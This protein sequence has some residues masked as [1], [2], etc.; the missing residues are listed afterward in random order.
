MVLDALL[1]AAVVGVLPGVL[2]GRLF[3]SRRTLLAIGGAAAASS[4]TAFAAP[5]TVPLP[6]TGRLGAASKLSVPLRDLGV[7][8]QTGQLH[9]PNWLLGSWRLHN[10]IT[11]FTMPLGSAFADGFTA[12]SARDD[13][14]REVAYDYSMRFLAAPVG[15]DAAAEAAGFGVIQDRAY[16]AAEETRAF[17]EDD[18][19]RVERSRYSSDRQVAPHGLI[20]LELEED[21]A[22][23]ART[24]IQLEVQWC[25]WQLL[26]NGAFVT[27]EM[28]LQRLTT[29]GVAG[30]Q[31]IS[32][33]TC[34]ESITCFEPPRREARRGS[35]QSERET[36]RARNRLAQ[37]LL[38]SAA[39][40]GKVPSKAE[41]RADRMAALAGGRAVTF[42]DYDWTLTRAG[43]GELPLTGRPV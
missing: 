12:Y 43:S 5:A 1:C 37:Y 11:G 33:F 14:H 39:L 13:I 19:V 10:A 41:S 26:E 20:I 27:D 17:L 42:F 15:E 29:S 21:G 8:S 34:I 25:Q 22:E 30:Q 35:G 3:T 2:P 40:D 23:A 16:N 18:G 7:A 36:V 28:I 32:E 4:Q 38:P 24:T 31:P 6:L 9:Y